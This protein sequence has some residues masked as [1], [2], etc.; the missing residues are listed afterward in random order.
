M[1]VIHRHS[2]CI[3]P[4]RDGSIIPH[5]LSQAE[6]NTRVAAAVKAGESLYTVNGALID[7]I[8]PD[9]ILT[10]GL[11]DVPVVTPD[12]IEASLRGV[13][14][15]LPRKTRVLSFTGDCLAG[16]RDDFGLAV[17]NLSK[18]RNPFG[19][20]INRDG[21]HGL[22]NIDEAGLAVEWVDPP[23]SPDIGA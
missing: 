2:S 15:Q 14:C 6:I 19:M 13:K 16:I 5:G 18:K 8:S 3:Y 20:T 21:H 17:S 4:T 10:Q 23:Y 11:C 9:L 22:R 1:S 7:D 12:V